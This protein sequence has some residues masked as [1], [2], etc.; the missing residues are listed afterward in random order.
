M[1][2]NNDKKSERNVPITFDYML[3]IL[4]GISLL[5][6][7][8]F[9]TIVPEDIKIKEYQA[10]VLSF[11]GALAVAAIGN[12]IIGFI[13]KGVSREASRALEGPIKKL[14]AAAEKLRQIQIFYEAGVIG[15]FANRSSA[16]Q[17]FW[18]EIEREDTSIDFVGTSLL[19]SLDP[20][21]ESEKKKHLY[22]LL[23][24]KTK[25]DVKIRAL[26]MHPAYGSFREWVENRERGAVA[27][28]IQ[29]TLKYLVKNTNI[30]KD[31]VQGKPKE[32]SK[33]C[34]LLDRKYIRLYPG[35]VTA[36]AIFTS[37]AML[38]NASTLHGPVYDNFTLI[39]EDTED[40]NSIYKK[41]RANHF[42][43][44]WRSEKTVRLDDGTELDALINTDFTSDDYRFKE[45]M[46]WPPSDN[47]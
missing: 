28:D 38:V 37:R 31:I 23:Q 46:W 5:L 16:M 42:E 14:D 44:P 27:K 30:D 34:P 18:S 47:S 15:V 43:E 11:L 26:L 17:F 1:G 3:L 29:R 33:Q 2:I 41:F 8:V 20:A 45:G 36:Y 10:P 13:Q 40:P 25:N 7:S 12:I 39:I 9:F 35:I 32:E 4:A 21:E 22:Y 24:Q 19:G 6:G